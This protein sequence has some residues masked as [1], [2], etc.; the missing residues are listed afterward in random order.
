MTKPHET[1]KI[2]LPARCEICGA[3]G[4]RTELVSR[5]YDQFVVQNIPEHH[6]DVCGQAYYDY[7]TLMALDE[8]RDHPE[9]YALQTISFAAISPATLAA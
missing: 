1:K 6:C 4:L 9:R 8:A 7:D 5:D 2:A 3:S